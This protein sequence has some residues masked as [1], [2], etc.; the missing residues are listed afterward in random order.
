VRST[1]SVRV[2]VSLPNRLAEKVK[3]KAEELGLSMSG[4]VVMLVAQSLQAE[5]AIKG[6]S[7][8]VDVLSKVKQEDNTD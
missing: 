2:Q 6:M 4:T 1:N 7:G 3:K 5:D 8:L